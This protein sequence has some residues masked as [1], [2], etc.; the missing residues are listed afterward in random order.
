MNRQTAEKIDFF[1]G[2]ILSRLD[3]N[4]DYFLN[5]RVDFY[6]GN[7]KYS[8]EAKY[9]EE[10]F[11]FVFCGIKKSLSDSEFREFIKGEVEKYERMVLAW[12]E[13]GKTIYIEADG[14]KVATKTAENAA[15]SLDV[16]ESAMSDREYYI[17]RGK[18]DKLLKVI[19]ILGDN[20]KVRNDKVRKYNQTDHFVELIDGLL[21]NMTQSDKTVEIVDC[22]CGKSYLSFVLNYYIREVL[23]KKCHFTCIDYNKNVI[24]ASKKMAEE[25]GY[26]NMDFVHCDLRMYE[27]DRKFDL[28]LTLHACDT[29]TDL[30][31]GFAIEHDVKNIVCVPCCHREMNSQ[32]SI[33]GFEKVLKYGVIKARIADNLTDGLRAMYLEGKGYDTSLVEYISPLDTPKNLMLRA[34]K[35]RAPDP[36]ILKEYDR[37]CEFLGTRLTLRNY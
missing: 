29:A 4:G 13:R 27:S 30:A 35:K 16:P 11:V 8:L 31:L 25:L 18:A 1:L 2:G 22:A 12:N 28:L 3:D 21:K 24:E 36:N 17:K 10:K 32:Y 7:K 37:I 34:E 19:G 14:K 20:G 15:V 6:S 33:P 23:G 9:D 26:A 5:C